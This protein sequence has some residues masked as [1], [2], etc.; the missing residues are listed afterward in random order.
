MIATEGYTVYLSVLKQSFRLPRDGMQCIGLRF[1]TERERGLFREGKPV[2]NE[3]ASKR[4]VGFPVSM[5]SLN[6]Q[7]IC[8]KLQVSLNCLPSTMHP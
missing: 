4:P 3:V 2:T 1:K 6:R 8:T 7:T 5:V